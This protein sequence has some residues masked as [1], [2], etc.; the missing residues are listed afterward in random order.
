[1]SVFLLILKIIGIVI[2]CIIGLVLFIVLYVLLA[3][4]W[5]KVQGSIDRD[6]NY[7]F[8]VKACTF[9]HFIQVHVDY[10]KDD[11]LNYNVSI[12]GTL[13]R[14]LPRKKKD[15]DAEGSEGVIEED[16]DNDATI[17]SV[18]S[19]ESLEDEPAKDEDTVKEEVTE[20]STKEELT[21]EDM[22]ASAEKV[23]D[24]DDIS[25]IDV[26]SSK[27]VDTESEDF[28]ERFNE[29]DRKFFIKV[30]EFFD[31]FNPKKLYK[32]MKAKFEEL[33]KDIDKILSV[34]FN[35]S[36]KE[37]LGKVM[38][39]LKKLI[40]SL[41]L[42]MRGTDLDFSLGSPD[43]TGQVSGVLA[44]FPPIYD[45]KVRIIPDFVDEELYFDGNVYIKG[46]LQLVFVV[47]FALAILLDSNTKRII[48]EIKQL[49]N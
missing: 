36:N 3:P 41:G 47:I 25:D 28:E 46:K 6:M 15:E 23:T 27:I 34:I 13:V 30:R 26:N 7:S 8:K 35:D 12:L 1:M 24:L 16:I 18:E 2:L 48:N 40:K 11:G 14:I 17:E 45:K 44:L 9:L 39:E 4:F 20:D 10:L 5:F 32:K 31:R 33:K 37:W 38:R 49:K 29:E 42:N 21:S 22:S 19:E 43:T